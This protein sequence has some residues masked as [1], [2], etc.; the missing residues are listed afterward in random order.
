MST[1]N[2]LAWSLAVILLLLGATV[3]VAPARAA[4]ASCASGASPFTITKVA[5]GTSGSPQSV[6][7]GDQNVPL[8]VTMLYSGPC[9]SSQVD[10][11]LTFQNGTYIT[12]FVGP[13]GL[14]Q[15]KDVAVNVAPNTVVTETFDFNVEQ[16]ATT[17]VVYYIPLV[18]QYT[19]S[20]TSN[21]FTEFTQAPIALY[22]PVLL[23]LA[24]STTHLL[25]GTLNN[26]TISISNT[27]SASSG[28]VAIAVTAPNSVTVLN[29]LS[30]VASLAPGG[31][32]SQVLQLYVP[33]SL[34]GTAFSLT[35][36]ADYIDAYSNSQSVTQSL[37]F[38][39]SSSTVEAAASWVVEGAQWGSASSTTSPLPGTQDTPLVVSLQYLGSTPVTSLQGTVQLP[40]GVTDLNGRSSA[41]A[42]S[43]ATTNQYGAVQ[44]TF[45][46]NLASTVNPGSYNFTL[47][48]VWMTSQ[49]L[50]LT[51]TAVLTPPPIAPLQSSFEVEGATWGTSP[52]ASA[53]VPGMQNEPLVVSLQYLGVTS[54]TSVKGTLTLPAGITDLNGNQAA[55]AYA[56]SASANQVVTLTF[57]VDVGGSVKPGSYNFT[58][59]LSWI[60]SVSLT[61]T[62]SSSLSPPPIA[63]PATSF[64]FSLAQE[65][66]TVVAGSQTSAAFQLTNHGTA[67]IYLPTFT[68]N[69]GSVIV[70]ASTG[71]P[72]PVSELDP[73]KNTTFS[74]VL[75]SGP[76]A[77]AG[78]YAGTL[79]VSFTDSNGASHTQSFP[80]AFTLEGTVIL[81]LQDTTVTQS[82]T[83]FTVT[84]SILDEGS[85]SAYYASVSG[86]LGV[87]FA[88]PVYIG[89]IDPNSP[90]PF[91]V[92]IPFTA[93]ASVATSGSSTTT[94]RSFSRSFNSSRTTSGNFTLPA[95]FSV[96]GGFAGFGGLGNRSSGGGASVD[97]A[98]S[99]T[100]KDSFGN[101]KVQAFTVPTTEK[102]ASQ[103]FGG[104]VSTTTQV[105]SGPDYLTYLAYGVVAAVAV[106][107]VAGALM[108]RRYR[109]RRLPNLPGQEREEPAVI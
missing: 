10:Y 58:L 73:G 86:L 84:G 17:G 93:P 12:P 70:I 69:V 33:T 62:Q 5:W 30:P 59:G 45:S 64:Q 9:T 76:S 13:Y 27:G 65:N 63:S 22:G 57:Y 46:L 48:L 66:S 109:A 24:A 91:S 67:P 3:Y 78:I 92:T 29:Q 14:T 55:T 71:S 19:D 23:N 37:G 103:L 56:A 99:L 95:N 101:N 6:Y 79:T 88:T 75:T 52:T 106:V 83:G 60:T 21:V 50:G 8:T 49:S 25:A 97:I 85:A 44:L 4:A 53:P 61:M 100:F 89:E 80:V 35:L 102:T 68:L 34:S 87:N 11:N 40:A 15:L 47:S 51:E 42:F 2:S 16:S 96:P 54:V 20:S 7:P 104:G 108:L 18:I 82:S 41:V 39:V 32:S 74:A 36:T 43:S 38:L 94:S 28:P 26:V 81:V 98:I 90:V 31:N 1:R 77:T 105:S 72:V 107:L